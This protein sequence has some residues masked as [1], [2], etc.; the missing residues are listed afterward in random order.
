[1][2]HTSDSSDG[3]ELYYLTPAGNLMSV[4]LRSG[5][6]LQAGIPKEMF[7]TGFQLVPNPTQRTLRDKS[8]L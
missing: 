2:A 1:V 6:P 7:G 4:E 8:M 5:P 3:K